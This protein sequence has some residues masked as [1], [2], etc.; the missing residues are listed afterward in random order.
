MNMMGI[1]DALSVCEISQGP[2]D[3]SD[4]FFDQFC[5]FFLLLPEIPD[6][7]KDDEYIGK[8]IPLG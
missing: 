3:S 6:K 4:S 2:V 8:I 7:P 5:L 1:G